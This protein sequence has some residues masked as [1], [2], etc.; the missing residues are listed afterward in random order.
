[1]L[2]LQYH[3]RLPHIAPIGAT[4]FVTFRLGDSLP[5]SVLSDLKEKSKKKIEK[6]NHE[7]PNDFNILIT[8]E[9]KNYFLQ[10]DR[11]L[12][13][14]P[15]GECQLR[16]P[17]VA[18]VM[19]ECLV[20]LNGKYYVMIAYC[21]MPNHVHLLFD[22]S[23]QLIN[24][25]TTLI[26]K[27]PEDYVQLNEIMGYIKGRSS[28]QIKRRLDRKGRFWQKDSYDRYIRNEKELYDTVNYII[29]NP[30][31]AGLVKRWEDFP[32]TYLHND[33]I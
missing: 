4:F 19:Q 20:E 17:A 32:Y 30:V 10:I 16:I 24:K 14:N 21:I 11:F 33:F 28:F 23:I 13:R 2:K 8:K 26:E 3:N 1:M 15:L 9:Q 25:N 6:L 27:I 7:K 12:D 29:Q 22:T 5:S 31:S 18:D